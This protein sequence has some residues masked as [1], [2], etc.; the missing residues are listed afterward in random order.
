VDVKQKKTK[1]KK[2]QK[3]KK[4]KKNMKMHVCIYFR[5]L[6]TTRRQSIKKDLIF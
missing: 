4:N 5:D 2:K 6:F 3:Q 1:R